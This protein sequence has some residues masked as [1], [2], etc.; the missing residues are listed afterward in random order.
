MTSFTIMTSFM[1]KALL[2]S[3]GCSHLIHLTAMLPY[4]VYKRIQILCLHNSTSM[5]ILLILSVFTLL[6]AHDIMAAA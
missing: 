6:Y 3:F 5:R 2:I 1:L 4:D